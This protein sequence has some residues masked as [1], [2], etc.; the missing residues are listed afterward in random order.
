MM[1]TQS[2]Y[3]GGD[4]DAFHRF[5]HRTMS[6]GA[7]Y[8]RSTPYGNFEPRHGFQAEYAGRPGA[9]T[10]IQEPEGLETA[11]PQARRRIAVAVRECISTP[12]LHL[13][14]MHLTSA[15]DADVERSSARGTQV[16]AQAVWHAGIPAQT[17]TT[18]TSIA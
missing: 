9:F 3:G 15:R 13:T 6:N 17:Y 16:M 10:L 18:A 14:D 2:H 8:D 4:L 5:N 1:M 12:H 11:G 7:Y